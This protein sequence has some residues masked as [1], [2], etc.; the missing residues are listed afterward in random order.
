VNGHLAK[1][2]EKPVGWKVVS[3]VNF[4]DYGTEVVENLQF[5]VIFQDA[6]NNQY[7]ATLSL[8]STA[9]CTTA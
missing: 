7:I 1:Y 2:F 4:H 9:A 5:F 3:E 6:S 8:C